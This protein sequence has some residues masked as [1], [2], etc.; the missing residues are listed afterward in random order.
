M[1]LEFVV[2]RLGMRLGDVDDPSVPEPE[3]FD[4]SRRSREM[5]RIASCT[6]DEE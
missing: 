3:S 1:L 4:A 6:A 2:R 5:L